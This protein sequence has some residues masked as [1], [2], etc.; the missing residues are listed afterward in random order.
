MP[1]LVSLLK[2]NKMTLVVALP[3]VNFEL[4]EAAI[5]GGA[6]A[7]QLNIDSGMLENLDQQKE[8]IC[9]IVDCVKHPIGISFGKTTQVNDQ[10]IKQLAEIGFDFINLGLEHYH[11]EVT[12]LKRVSKI[13][14]LN[15][16]FT[17]EELVDIDKLGVMALDAAIV[18]VSGKGENLLVGDLQNYISIAA[19]AGLPVI[20][21][22]QR[23][24]LP[25]EV[26]IIADTGAKGLLLTSVV[27][28]T[29]AKH[30]A[31]KVGQFRLAVDELAQ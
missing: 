15:S 27:T 2:D 5:A 10:Q 25:S 20:V 9:K 30:I 3:T 14:S 7:L 11:G 28:G 16:R 8:S 17:L 26:A 4:A 23:I 13:L 12:R 29:T 22:T 31:D 6:D 18:P 19:S 1:R 24:I 21:P